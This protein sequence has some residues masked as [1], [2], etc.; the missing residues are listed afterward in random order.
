[1]RRSKSG[2]ALLAMIALLFGMLVATSSSA[3]ASPSPTITHSD[4]PSA[5]ASVKASTK[6]S[7]A[8]KAKAKRIAKAKAKAKRAAAKRKAA[9][10]AS[11]PAIKVLVENAS[12]P[13]AVP[14][15]APAPVADNRPTPRPEQNVMTDRA[16][17]LWNWDSNDAVV[18]FA[19]RNNVTEI[20][21]Y[22]HPGFLQ[23]AALKSRLTD[24]SRKGNAAGIRMW[25]MGGDPSWVTQHD[26][27][28][29]W[30]RDV[31]SSGLFD[32]V[33]FDIEPHSQAGYWDNQQTRNDAYLEL[34]R[35]VNVAAGDATLDLSLPWWFHTIS[36]GDT[37]LDVAA[38]SA[39]DQVTIVTFNQTKA[40]IEMNAER[41]ATVAKQQGKRYRL[42]SE[43]NRVDTDWITFEGMTNEQMLRVQN[44]VSAELQD[45]PLYLGFAVQEYEGWR[46]LA[47]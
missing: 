41:A 6:K 35:D 40:G 30:V 44:S 17:W 10:K 37:T 25:A 21:T 24:L 45:D 15:P 16:M 46:A 38:I 29:G 39:V 43:T 28:L 36:Y 27:A 5:R 34:L 18:D 42:A 9:A 1:M 26:V 3:L 22:A 20:F 14:T 13:V 33:H 11:A 23:D 32:G 47:R 4:T 2:F 12:T 19:K 31:V 7:A 8:A